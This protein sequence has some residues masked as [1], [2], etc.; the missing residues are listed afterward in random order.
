MP[1]RARHRNRTRR[2]A[3]KGR[4]EKGRMSPCSLNVQNNCSDSA[5]APS[6]AGGG[7]PGWGRLQQSL[8]DRRQRCAGLAADA[9]AQFFSGWPPPQ[10]SPASGGG[11]SLPL[12]SLNVRTNCSDSAVAPSPAGGGRLGWGHF[13]RSLSDRRWR[14]MGLAVAA[15]RRLPL[16]PLAGEGRDG[17]ASSDRCLIDDSGVQAWRLMPGCGFPAGPL[18]NPPPQA[19]EGAVCLSALSTCGPT[20]AIRRLPLPPLAGEGLDEGASNDRCLIDDGG[21]RA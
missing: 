2:R 9:R 20:A 8:S 14:C 19:G 13:Q 21:V 15:I 17:G 5:L 10:P 12:R 7:R 1:V 4:H 6:P 3:V 18:P 16:P 11:S